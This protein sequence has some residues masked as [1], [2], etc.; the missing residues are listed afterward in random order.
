MIQSILLV[1]LKL[2][3][4][5]DI[6]TILAFILHSCTHCF[7]QYLQCPGFFKYFSFLFILNQSVN[8]SIRNCRIFVFSNC[9]LTSN[10]NAQETEEGLFQKSQNTEISEG[11]IFL[12]MWFATYN[13]KCWEFGIYLFQ[14]TGLLATS[15]NCVRDPSMPHSNLCT[16]HAWTFYRCD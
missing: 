13:C 10:H 12:K 2:P 11:N 7:F 5:G 1:G 4:A 14:K 6:S 15:L 8:Q 9:V 3:A 16:T